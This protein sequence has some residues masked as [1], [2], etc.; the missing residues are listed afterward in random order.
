ME[1]IVIASVILL[2]I[3]LSAVKVV[4]EYERAVI[5]RFGRILPAK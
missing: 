5:F 3:V 1:P 2:F 4:K